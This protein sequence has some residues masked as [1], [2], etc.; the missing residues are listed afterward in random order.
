[1]FFGMLFS[2]MIKISNK[3]IIIDANPN[4]MYNEVL[5]NKKLIPSIINVVP[6][7]FALI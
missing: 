6:M 5:R 7:I 3:P 2:V 4:L 1:M